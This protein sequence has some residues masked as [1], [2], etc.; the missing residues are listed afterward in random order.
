[1]EA[2]PSN[3]LIMISNIFAKIKNGKYT[4]VMCN[5]P[6]YLCE[7]LYMCVHATNNSLQWAF[8]FMIAFGMKLGVV[9]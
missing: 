1:M 2:N 9:N 6:V 8:Q 5:L 3:D 7:Y 4:N